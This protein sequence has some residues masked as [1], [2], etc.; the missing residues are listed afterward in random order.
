MWMQCTHA[1]GRQVWVNFSH[2]LTIEAYTAGTEIPTVVRFSKEDKL[3]LKEPV[4]TLMEM[5]QSNRGGRSG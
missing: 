4:S 1:D 3:V 5:L 2:V